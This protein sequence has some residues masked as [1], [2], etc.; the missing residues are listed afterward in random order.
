MFYEDTALHF[1]DNFVPTYIA[2]Y[3]QKYR[4]KPL[5]QYI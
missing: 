4:D 2:Q 5:F 1:A 3:M